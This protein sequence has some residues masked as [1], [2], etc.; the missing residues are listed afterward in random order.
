MYILPNLWLL[1]KELQWETANLFLK[2]LNPSKGVTKKKRTPHTNEAYSD[3]ANSL[4]D[5]SHKQKCVLSQIVYFPFLSFIKLSTEKICCVRLRL[6]SPEEHSE[7]F[8]LE[9]A[10]KRLKGARVPWA[11]TPLLS[12]EEF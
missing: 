10:A 5:R 9:R 7:M 4:Q 11:F 6:S 8:N 2:R 12:S 3:T 1:T